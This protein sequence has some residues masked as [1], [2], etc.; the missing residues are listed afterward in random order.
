MIFVLITAIIAA[1]AFPKSSP[2]A[3][4]DCKVNFIERDHYVNPNKNP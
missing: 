1:L 3:G 4:K 2:C